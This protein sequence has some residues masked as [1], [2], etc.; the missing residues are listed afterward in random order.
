MENIREVKA[1]T[2][3]REIAEI[4]NRYV[5]NTT[6]TFELRPLTEEE[7]RGRIEEVAAKFPYYVWEEEGIILGYCYAHKWK[8]FAAYDITL[9]STIYLLP[10]VKGRGIGMKL[11]K[12]LIDE[13]RRRGFISL[14]ACI[15]AE[16]EESCRFHEKLGFRQVSLFRNVGKKFG[17][18]LDVADYQL[19]LNTKSPITSPDVS[20]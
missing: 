19:G 6:A 3:A 4:Y 7:M 20:L 17:R 1:A 9:E 16:N 13:C 10:D 2:D 12:R 8:G 18:L 5:A 11:M 14:I 15:T